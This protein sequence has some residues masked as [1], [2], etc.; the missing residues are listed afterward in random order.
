M[1][2]AASRLRIEIDS[3]PRRG[4]H[5][6]SASITQM[7]IEEQAL[8]KESD[9]ASNANAWRSCARDIASVARMTSIARKAEWR[10]EKDVIENVQTLKAD[11]ESAQAEEE[12]VTREGD[13]VARLR[14]ALFHAFPS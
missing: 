2:E 6:Q 5:W 7:Q 14:A 12:R 1:D 8:M 10:N 9:D 4:R 11:L 3:M 13:L